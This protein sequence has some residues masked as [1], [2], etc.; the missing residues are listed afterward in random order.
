LPCGELRTPCKRNAMCPGEV[1]PASRLRIPFIQSVNSERLR[2][3]FAKAVRKNNEVCGAIR[4][5]VGKAGN[6]LQIRASGH[7]LFFMIFEATLQTP[8]G[9]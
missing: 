3:L 4:F 2:W 6:N 1:K 8:V 5:K 7:T 9:R